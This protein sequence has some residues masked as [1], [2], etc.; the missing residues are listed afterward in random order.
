MDRVLTPADVRGYV[1][2]RTQS[3]LVG[4]RC[5][6]GRQSSSVSRGLTADMSH[7]SHRETLTQ[8][9]SGALVNEDGLADRLP[10]AQ[11][12]ENAGRVLDRRALCKVHGDLARG[13]QIQ[14][15]PQDTCRPGSGRPQ[16]WL[17]D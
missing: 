17:R 6:V 4:Q 5:C 13:D 15:A 11:G 16:S 10:V 3:G 8:E 9:I 1:L 7:A 2:V 12:G 14:S